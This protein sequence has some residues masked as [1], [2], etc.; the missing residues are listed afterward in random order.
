LI[1]LALLIGTAEPHLC[2]YHDDELSRLPI[3]HRRQAQKKTKY[4]NMP[5]QCDIILNKEDIHLVDVHHADNGL[6]VLGKFISQRPQD[7][8]T[9]QPDF[10]ETAFSHSPL[11]LYRIFGVT[12]FPKENGNALFH[13]FKMHAQFLERVDASLKEGRALSHAW[14]ILA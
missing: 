2:W 14:I 4:Q 11:S 5:C 9:T 6:L 8:T 3:H 12:H 13:T 10:I 7:N 1:G